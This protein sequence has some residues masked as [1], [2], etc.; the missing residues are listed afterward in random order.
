VATNSN[1]RKSQARDRARARQE[2]IRKAERRRRSL[3]YGL[4]GVVALVVVLVLVFVVV[5]IS[6]TKNGGT[7]ITEPA[8]AAVVS[9]ITTIPSSAFETAGVAAVNTTVA[10][11]SMISGGAPITTDGL[12]TFVYVGGEFCPYCAAERWAITAALSRFG[13]FSGLDTTRSAATDGNYA[14]LSFLHAKYTSRYVA[15]SGTEEEDRA[16]KVIAMPPAAE[17]ASFQKY[18]NNGFPYLTI[19]DVYR[20]TYQYD[21]SALGTM[22]AEQI[23]AAAKDPTTTLGKDI[24]TSANV[25]SAGICAVDGQQPAAVC[26][27]PAVVAGLA[28]LNEKA[29]AASG[30]SAG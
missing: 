28:D 20:A 5:N 11:L 3:F 27:S 18:G 14:T 4:G 21:P 19:N 6:D 15:F 13:T 10:G 12:P 23:A 8:S 29:G 9:D 22:T 24:L 2:A 1:D 26:T 16:Q 17:N 7:N 30:S 25:L